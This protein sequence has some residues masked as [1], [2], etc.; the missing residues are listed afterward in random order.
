MKKH[1][2]DNNVREGHNNNINK[3]YRHSSRVME[4]LK[5]KGQHGKKTHIEASN[6]NEEHGHNVKKQTQM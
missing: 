6:T 4:G 2:H 5:Y 3:E 1:G